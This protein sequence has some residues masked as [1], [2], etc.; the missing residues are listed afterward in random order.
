MSPSGLLHT[1]LAPVLSDRTR[2]QIT[3]SKSST[4]SKTLD[5]F[6]TWSPVMEI[7][8][9]FIVFNKSCCCFKAVSW[10]MICV[11]VV[12]CVQAAVQISI[13]GWGSRPSDWLLHTGNH[14]VEHRAS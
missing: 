5:V 9:A 10:F 4:E 11:H 1:V 7:R 6:R 12:L 8:R 3:T 2:R 13:A 14:E